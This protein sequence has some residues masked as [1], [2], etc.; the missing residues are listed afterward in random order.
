MEDKKLKDFLE[1][2]AE[3]T[4]EISDK[5]QEIEEYKRVNKTFPP[6]NLLMYVVNKSCDIYI[7]CKEYFQSAGEGDKC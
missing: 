3:L 1:R 7:A 2:L 5:E 4:N 6:L